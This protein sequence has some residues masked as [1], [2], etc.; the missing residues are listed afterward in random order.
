MSESGV[1]YVSTGAAHAT[2]PGPGIEREVLAYNQQLMLV[3]HRFEKGWT[4][5]WHSHPQDQLVYVLSGRVRLEA[6]GKSWELQAG[7]SI[8]IEGAVEHMAAALEDSEALDVFA[9]Y[10]EDF[11]K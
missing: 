5:P 2:K 8:A 7:D 1:V 10:R 4:G 9:P 11:T 3:R 6:D